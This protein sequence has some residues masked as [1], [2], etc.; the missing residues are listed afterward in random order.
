MADSLIIWFL[1][2]SKSTNMW[3]RVWI[4]T[5]TIIL[6]MLNIDLPA[7]LVFTKGYQGFDSPILVDFFG[8]PQWCCYPCSQGRP[9]ILRYNNRVGSLWDG[10][11][12]GGPYKFHRHPWTMSSNQRYARNLLVHVGGPEASKSKSGEAVPSVP[13]VTPWYE[14]IEKGSNYPPLAH[15]QWASRGS[16]HLISRLGMSRYSNAITIHGYFNNAHFK[17]RPLYI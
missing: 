1:S 15:K 13:M 8:D 9:P 11:I 12:I 14:K 3:M 10:A 2:L 6:E 7:I 17:E 16:F 4:K 5:T